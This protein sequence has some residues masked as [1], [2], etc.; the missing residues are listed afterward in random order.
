MAVLDLRRDG[1][2]V[3]RWLRDIMACLEFEFVGERNMDSTAAGDL[4]HP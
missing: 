3:V 1:A 4:H 2:C